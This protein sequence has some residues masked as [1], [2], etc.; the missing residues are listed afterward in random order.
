M[1]R[2]VLL[3][4]SLL[5]ISKHV[6]CMSGRGDA[7]EPLLQ[8]GLQTILSVFPPEE[9]EQISESL[10]EGSNCIELMKVRAGMRS[11][12]RC[13]ESE[14]SR[15]QA[16]D[17]VQQNLPYLRTF[18]DV[19]RRKSG[20]GYPK[21][22]SQILQ[23]FEAVAHIGSVQAMRSLSEDKCRQELDQMLSTI[24]ERWGER[25][26]RMVEESIADFATEPEETRHR[27]AFVEVRQ[28]GWNFLLHEGIKRWCSDS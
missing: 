15:C 22:P 4:L 25:H 1:K 23:A 26:R 24:Q 7:Y 12:Q 3:M 8:P 9:R 17:I 2:R 11:I 19:A 20:E 28:Q 21:K 13:P 16:Q 5:A 14:R 6:W 27:R 18:E 10:R